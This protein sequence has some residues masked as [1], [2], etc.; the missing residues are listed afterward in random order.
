MK[1]IIKN[2]LYAI[3]YIKQVLQL[4]RNI[5]YITFDGWTFR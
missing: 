3:S 4:V 5:I 1:T 2:F